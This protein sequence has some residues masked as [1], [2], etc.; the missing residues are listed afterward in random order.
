LYFTLLGKTEP[1]EWKSMTFA[2]KKT[3][4]QSSTTTTVEE[5][6]FVLVETD[7]PT[8][9]QT[10]IDISQIS[11]ASLPQENKKIPYIYFI[12]LGIALGSLVMLGA[13]TTDK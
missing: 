8:V 12:I 11:M 2:E 3:F 5:K 10:Q 9:N 13:Y 6:N 4:V 7:E 1:V